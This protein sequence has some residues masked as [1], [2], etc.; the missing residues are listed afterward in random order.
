MSLSFV[1]ITIYHNFF[2]CLGLLNP[3]AGTK[4]DSVTYRSSVAVKRSI[5]YLKMHKKQEDLAT[6]SD[7]AIY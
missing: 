6:I 3:D 5:V 4:V 2:S 7:K 1:E